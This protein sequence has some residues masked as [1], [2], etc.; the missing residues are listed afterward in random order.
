MFI[1]NT[2]NIRS[3]LIQPLKKQLIFY[4]INDYCC[5][6]VMI[7]CHELYELFNSRDKSINLIFVGVFY[8]SILLYKSNSPIKIARQSKDTGRENIN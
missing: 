1:Y 4:Y 3:R 7:N 8:G 2:Y 5:V 6:M